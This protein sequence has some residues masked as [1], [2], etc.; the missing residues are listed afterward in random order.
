MREWLL[1]P[2]ASVEFNFFFVNLLA[3][4][5]LLRRGFVGGVWGVGGSPGLLNQLNTSVSHMWVKVLKR[6]LFMH[7]VSIFILLCSSPIM[8]DF[9]HHFTSAGRH[10]SNTSFGQTPADYLLREHRNSPLLYCSE[11]GSITITRDGRINCYR[12]SHQCKEHVKT[13]QLD[14][15]SNSLECAPTYRPLFFETQFAFKVSPLQKLWPPE[16]CTGLHWLDTAWAQFAGS[17]S[18]NLSR[19]K[20]RKQCD[21]RLQ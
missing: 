6:S 16:L 10:Q 7:N 11:A 5:T 8:L 17:C 14:I 19:K 1:F 15:S 2:G 12:A 4:Y 20:E 9:L 3:R 18:L 13:P 21:S